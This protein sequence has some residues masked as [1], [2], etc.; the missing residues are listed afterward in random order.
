MS[1]K[2]GHRYE[3]G[4][5]RLDS[6]PPSLWRDESLVPL[7]PK[8]LEMLLLLVRQREIIVSREELLE[9]VWRD[10]FVEDGN[11]NYTVSLLRKTLDKDN[12]GRFIQTVPKRGYR[13]VA[14]VLEVSANGH[15]EN[16]VRNVEV[17]I[18]TEELKPKIRWHSI[19]IVLLGVLFVTGFVTWRSLDHGKKLSTTAV[20]NRNIRTVAVL[21]LKT[22]A[23]DDASKSL[24]LGLTDSLISRLGS[25]NRFSVRPLSSV[26]DYAEVD[27]DPLKFGETLKVDVILE[28][29]LQQIDNRLRANVRLWDLRDGAQLWQGSFDSTEAD[30]FNLQDAVAT[31][32][33]RWLLSELLEKDRELLTRRYTN[34]PEAFR[35]YVRGR[36][37]L[38]AKNPDNFEKAVDEFQKAVALDP[39]F[40]LA[41]AGLADASTRQGFNT[42]GA[43]QEEFYA[44]SK[45]LAEKAL[46]LDPETPEA[47]AALGTVKRIYDW[48]WAGAEGDFRRAIE[49]NPNYARAHLGYALLLS[50]LGRSDEALVEIKRAMEIDPL[51]QDVKSGYLTILEGRGQYAEALAQAQENMKFNK[52]YRRGMRGVATFLFHLGEYPRVIEISE[53]ELTTRNSQEFAWLSLLVTS[54]HRSGQIGQRD[55]RLKQLEEVARADTKALYALAE[56]YA[57]LGRTN[58][59]LAALE[60][61]IEVREERMMWLKVEP[62]LANLKGNARFDEILR[63]MNLASN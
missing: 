55:E 10:T 52:E 39:T 59:A 60:K 49:L 13:F 17:A 26:R 33:M 44:R 34:N 6:E 56:N 32:A 37:I 8:A 41:Y 27:Q 1:S 9:T 19:G 2:N 54:H 20:T 50:C 15:A 11:I 58:D 30:F 12:K 40:A 63:R 42:S 31:G 18:P 28:G 21:P 53:Q 36:A 5:F 46:D 4:D 16:A 43:S 48:D 38:D 45:A 61:C 14:D 22:L 47:Y 57:E 51:S 62:R 29:T 23:E 24:S 35:T 7:P 3:F 25:L